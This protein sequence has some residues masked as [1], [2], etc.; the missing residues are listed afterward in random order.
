MRSFAAVFALILVIVTGNAVYVVQSG[1]TLSS[2]AVKNGTTVKA[3]VQANH[4]DNPDR[5][6]VGD[7]LTIPGSDTYVVQ[8]GDT[9][10]AVAARL[11]V[12][13]RQLAAANGIT[14]TNVI[15]VGTRLRLEGPQVAVDVA[16]PVHYTIRPGDTLG[17]IALRFSTSIDHLATMNAIRNPNVIKAGMDLIID[18]G[19]WIC[20]VP[21]ATFFNDWGFPRSGG[22]FHG[23]ND[24]FAPRG[25][26]VYAPVGGTVRQVIGSIGGNQVDLLGNDGTLYIASHLDRF[27]ATGNVAAGDVIGYVGNTG[28]AV[29]AR[30]HVH[31][32]LHPAGGEAVNPYP[33]LAKACK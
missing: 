27:G 20:P 4:L 18:E 10:E 19:A 8:P 5:I 32:E 12:S 21:G 33:V 25:T 11:G 3:L 7:T 31:F 24:L 15:Y 13:V 30:T 23:G 17:T 6:L 2:I 16:A 22:R 1:D 26:P 29:G 28:D 9:L 14:N